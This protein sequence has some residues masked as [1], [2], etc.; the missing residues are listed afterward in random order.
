MFFR[1][2][3]D[4]PKGRWR[5]KKGEAKMGRSQGRKGINP[6]EVQVVC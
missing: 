2:Q 1:I 5:R 4:K 3:D 6:G